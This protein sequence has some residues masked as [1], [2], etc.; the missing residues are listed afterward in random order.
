MALIAL[1]I[2]AAIRIQRLSHDLNAQ[3]STM[4]AAVANAD[5]WR[6]EKAAALETMRPIADK[7]KASQSQAEL[8]AAEIK[9]QNSALLAASSGGD[10]AKA[11]AQLQDLCG[12]IV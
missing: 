1:G 9:L 10:T 5:K 12:T 8:S 6:D 2:F 7:L 3:R 11:I 4:E